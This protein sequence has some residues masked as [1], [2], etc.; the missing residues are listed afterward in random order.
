[1]KKTVLCTTRNEQ[2]A[3]QVIDQLRAAKLL[4]QDISILFAYQNNNKSSQGR[5]KETKSGYDSAWSKE[6][7]V[8]EERS[9]T[10]HHV[11]AK[12]EK[13]KTFEG[14]VAL[15]GSL[16][17]LGNATSIT[18]PGSGSVIIAGPLKNA[19]GGASRTTS[20]GTASVLTGTLV[21]FGFSEAD[22][23]R[24]E[25]KLNKGMYL[26]AFQAIEMQDLNRAEDIF[27]KTGAEN[28]VSTLEAASQ[29]KVR[30]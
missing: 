12:T 17:R 21:G 26:I 25:D 6:G 3:Q 29:K 20:V 8:V 23:K 24:F 13:G 18:L 30:V 27:K 14:T 5:T 16:A 11:G 22:A 7:N 9:Q 1:M 4:L 19:F 2:Q 28:V 15:N 10:H